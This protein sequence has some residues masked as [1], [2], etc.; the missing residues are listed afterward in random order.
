MPQPGA[1]K[2]ELPISAIAPLATTNEARHLSPDRST[3]TLGHGTNTTGTEQVRTQTNGCLLVLCSSTTFDGA[4]IG[5]A[6]LDSGIDSAH[7]A[8]AKNSLLNTNRV[9]Y[10][11]GVVMGDSVQA[12]SALVN[13]DN[14]TFMRARR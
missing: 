13:G 14:T 8:F 9:V 4:G 2:V 6:V 3:Q 10:S 7:K 12:M 5:I 1:L 11:D